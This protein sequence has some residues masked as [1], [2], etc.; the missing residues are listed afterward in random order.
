MPFEKYLNIILRLILGSLAV[1]A[2]HIKNQNKTERKKRL[3][4][5]ASS[6]FCFLLQNFWLTLGRKIFFYVCRAHVVSNP[7]ESQKMAK[8]DFSY[9]SKYINFSGEKL[10][11]VG[12]GSGRKTSYYCSKLGMEAIG[13][14]INKS[15]IKK[16]HAR[17]QNRK[18]ER[19]DFLVADAAHLPFKRNS[20][21]NV[22]SNDAFEHI[23]DH[24]GTVSE[25]NRVVKLGGHIC[26]N[27]GPLW[28][29][30]FGSHLGFG[31]FFSPPWGHLFFSAGSIKDVLMRFGKF[32]EKEWDQFKHLNRITARE[33]EKTLQRTGLR[34][35]F[36]K[37]YAPPPFEPFLKTPLWEFFVTQIV[38]LLEKEST[39]S[40][41]R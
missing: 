21:D 33:F 3:R 37:L 29:S 26:I 6:F 35:S 39:G 27:F 13:V 30:P 36:L 32:R 17:V 38:T 15:F 40:I 22:I 41:D 25:M 11:D 19:V 28:H 12:C 31:E 23:S 20:F 34:I 5:R 9:Y 4:E 24:Q 14:D 7:Y 2:L 10:L 16:G 1:A 8:R 18:T